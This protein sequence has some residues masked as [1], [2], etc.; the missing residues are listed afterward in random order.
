[1]QLAGG[2]RPHA[3]SQRSWQRRFAVL[4]LSVWLQLVRS[5][6]ADRVERDVWRARAEV[7]AID[8]RR[9]YERSLRS[10]SAVSA[11]HAVRS[12][13]GRQA[14]LLNVRF[15]RAGLPAGSAG[16]S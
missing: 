7:C 8:R 5:A 10:L 16:G 9:Q 14:L 1:M 11:A 15:S 6:L 12:V 13:R 4:L 3:V 2:R